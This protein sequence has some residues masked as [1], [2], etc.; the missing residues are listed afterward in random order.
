M[1]LEPQQK[2]KPRSERHPILTLVEAEYLKSTANI[3]RS[4]WEPMAALVSEAEQSIARINAVD[5]PEDL[6]WVADATVKKWNQVLGWLKEL[7]TESG[8]VQAL[9]SWQMMSGLQQGSFNQP[10]P[11][12]AVMPEFPQP[13]PPGTEQPRRKNGLQL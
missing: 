6:Q 9:R 10:R 7:L 2:V 4:M 13:Q 1:N 5:I 12:A 11:S 8:S 3:P